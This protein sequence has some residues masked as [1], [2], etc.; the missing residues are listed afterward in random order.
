MNG[1]EDDEDGR[2]YAIRLSQQADQD[3]AEATLHLDRAAQDKT[4]ALQWLTGLYLEI[5]RLA[6]FPR[7]HAIATRESRLFGKETRRM[8]YR[9]S[10]VSVAYLVFFSVTDEGEDGPTV[11]VIPHPPRQQEADDPRRNAADT[12]KPM[13]AQT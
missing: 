7:H 1:S 11:S 10:A 13:M 5:G 2:S 9:R 6:T 4:L 12:G 8:V 3:A